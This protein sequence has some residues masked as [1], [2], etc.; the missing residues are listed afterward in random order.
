MMPGV[1]RDLIREVSLYANKF[2]VNAETTCSS[3]YDEICPNFDY[4]NDI[5]RRMSWTYDAVRRRRSEVRYGEGIIG[6]NDTQFV[7]GA[8]GEPDSEILATIGR[9]MDDYGLRRPFFMSFDPVPDTPLSDRSSSPLW[10]E[11]RLY[12]TSYLLKQYGLKYPDLESVLNDNGFLPDEDPKMVLARLNRDLF[13]VDINAASYS[14]LIR[15][16]GIGPRTANRILRCR[17]VLNYQQLASMGV[18]LKRARPFIIVAGRRQVD[19]GA[20]T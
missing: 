16:P 17:P 15:V 1:P 18:V 4:S 10:R 6:A 12:Q 5:L 8:T 13:P 11:V 14:E 3:R 19:L 9:F 20:F 7:I 2:G